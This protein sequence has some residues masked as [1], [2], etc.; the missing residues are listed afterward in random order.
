MEVV[1]KLS[2]ATTRYFLHLL[3]LGVNNRQILPEVG[4][5]WIKQIVAQIPR[6]ELILRTSDEFTIRLYINEEDLY[7]FLMQL[8]DVYAIDDTSIPVGAKLYVQ[9]ANAL[10]TV[11]EEGGDENE[12]IPHFI[13]EAT[14]TRKTRNTSRD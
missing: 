14:R 4:L 3:R 10:I 2:G 9:A 7:L 6:D 5:S 12:P 13:Q 11:Q 8:C 1:L